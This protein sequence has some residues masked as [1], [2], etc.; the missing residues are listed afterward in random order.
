MHG[1]P[2]KNMRPKSSQAKMAYV[3]FWAKEKWVE[4]W[5]FKWKEDSS[6]ELGGADVW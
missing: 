5:D 2:N 1:D 3:S 6:Q 4:I